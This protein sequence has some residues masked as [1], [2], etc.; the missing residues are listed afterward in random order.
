MIYIAG[1]RRLSGLFRHFSQLVAPACRLRMR[2]LH[3]NEASKIPSVDLSPAGVYESWPRNA[4]ADSFSHQ[5]WM[6]QRGSEDLLQVIYRPFSCWR[7]VSRASS[8]SFL[9][10]DDY[11]DSIIRVIPLNAASWL[12]TSGELSSSGWVTIS[13]VLWFTKFKRLARIAN[14][15]RTGKSLVAIA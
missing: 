10:V 1:F 3:C 4:G 11:L 6:R 14:Q 8:N 5:V 9:F 13:P 2:K 12:R 7:T 15:I